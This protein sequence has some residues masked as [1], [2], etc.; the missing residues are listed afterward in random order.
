MLA[1]CPQKTPQSAQPAADQCPTPEPLPPPPA[2]WSDPAALCAQAARG[3]PWSGAIPPLTP[4][5]VEESDSYAERV[6]SFLQN[7]DYR[8]PPY[9]WLSD[10]N[11]RMTGPFEGCA[12]NGD[13]RGP[14]P[15][16]RIYYSPEVIDWMCEYR[17]GDEQ[18]PDAA[19]MP[20]GAMI[21]KEMM[22]PNQVHLALVP[23]TN[24]LWIA[25]TPSQPADYYDQNFTSWTVMIK[26]ARGSADGWYYA[27]F[28]RSGTGNP[29]LWDK[30]GFSQ[31]DYPGSDGQPVTAPPPDT[32]WYPTYW[33]YTSPDVQYPNYGFGSYCVYCHASAQGEMTFASFDNIL[34][35]ETRYE[36]RPSASANGTRAAAGGDVHDDHSR[37]R[38]TALDQARTA[39]DDADNPRAPFP[40]PRSQPLSGFQA[41]FPELDPPYQRIWD[42]RLPAQTWDH[43]PSKLGVAGARPDHSQ[44]VTSDQCEGCHEA[45]GAG[46]L[47]Q[48]YMVVP[49]PLGAGAAPLDLS[50]WAEWNA[51]PMGLA[52]R[53]PIF[54]AQLELERN[55]A[56][57]QPGLAELAPCIDNTCL[58]C[59]GAAGA[60]QYNI[61]T[62]GQAPEDDPCKDFLPP[63]AE[64]AATN[65]DGALFTHEMVMSWR[66]ERPAQA[67]YGALAREGVTC[68]ICH[69]IAD[70][71]LDPDNL[72]KTFTG[73]FRV[74]PPEALYGPFPN[75]ASPEQ[76]RTQPMQNALGVEPM[77]GPQ[78]ARS[79]M[80]GTCH[81][82]FLPIFDQ[83]GQ[84][85]GTAY[86]QT[87][88][89][90]WLLSDFSAI[91]ADDSAGSDAQASTG[92]S[93]QGCHMPR[94]YHGQADPAPLTTG[95]ANIQDS[96]YPHAEFSLPADD[97]DV[98]ERPYRRHALYGLNGFINAFFQQFPLLLGYRQQD[99][100]NSKVRAPLL[101]ARESVLDIAR[102]QTA[103]AALSDVGWRD[104]H[105]HARLTVQN[106][107]GHNLPSGV[108]FRRLFV[109]FLVLDDQGAPIWASGRTDDIGRILAG[110]SATPLAT[111]SWQPGPNQT[112]MGLPFQ[113]HYQVITS[114]DQVQIYEEI[115]QNAGYEFTSSFIHRY[116][117]IKDNRLRPP[118]WNPTRVSDLSRREEYASATQPG[119]GP[120]RHWWP[121]PDQPAVYKDPT[122]PAIAGYPDTRGDRDYDLAAH[123]QRGLPGSD[124]LQYQIALSPAQAQR[125]RQVQVTLYSQSIPPHYLKE[126][127]ERAAEPGAEREAAERLHYIAGHLNTDAVADDGKPYLQGYK[128]R[129][130]QPV[131]VDVP[132]P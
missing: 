58:H 88:Y 65:Y 109:E 2:T 18:L 37:Q 56:R 106:L 129:V 31:A 46:Q 72:S 67:K 19:E 35:H 7:L 24:E 52:G 16:V 44:F 96:R 5:W 60:R 42:S 98:P 131:A 81:T 91:P 10:A 48:P 11:W 79:E 54:H 114:G 59:H 75:P 113:P 9:A 76:V 124:Q 92:K 93:C 30:S 102:T 45:G 15:A 14:H 97:I 61:D 17:Q 22:D 118:G 53:D 84:L 47:D 87:T 104:G 12:P 111:E 128:L 94:T 121:K 38:T 49:S 112:T 127:F 95:V 82:V 27:D 117:L 80:C 3:E 50:P 43:V 105:L 70:I 39:S 13:N 73:N 71:D 125:A 62:A 103:T 4:S 68:T 110:T 83:A 99:Y 64:R 21:I 74:G 116:W 77:Y 120:E 108:G 89:L 122:F 86:E 78:V 20:D 1:G 100:M 36:W 29:P 34:G 32:P 132:N 28:G 25:P 130:G 40:S 8:E 85:A 26:D 51:S 123:A 126:R 57:K 119:H 66:G 115:V 23:G 63:R 6:R 33:A 41:A 90:E 55:I 107:A 101:T 69:H